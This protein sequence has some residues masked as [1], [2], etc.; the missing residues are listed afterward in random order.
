MQRLTQ[1]IE[2]IRAKLDSLRRLSLKET[3]TRSIIID[4]L[5]E[6]LGWDIRNPN[7]VEQEYPTVDGKSVDYALKINGKPML[8]V[9]AKALDDPLNDVKAITQVVG[10]AANA[11]IVWCILTNGVKWKVYRSVEKCAAPDKQ[12]FEVCLDPRESGGIAVPQLAEQLW[13][14][15]RDET[16]KG[17]LDVL[18][19][20]IST[21]R[22]VFKALD[23]IMRDPPKPI[24]NAA[25]AS[26]GDE[27]LNPLKIKESIARIWGKMGLGALPAA[28]LAP[29][30][31]P[32][33]LGSARRETSRKAAET[34]RRIDEEGCYNEDRHLDGKPQEIV[35]LFR[36]IDGFC[37]SLRPG[38]VVKRVRKVYVSYCCG[39][40][41]FCYVTIFQRSVTL[42]LRLKYGLIQNPPP[43]A[44]D[45]S[46]QRWGTCEL[47]LT[48]SSLAQLEE[49]RPLVCDS[50]ESR[51]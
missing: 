11:G 33:A 42:Y 7:E 13:L 4:P 46:S 41:T 38:A 31:G 48:I 14:F 2:S 32:D 12:M 23:T 39:G 1:A 18:G 9:E 15:S 16:A 45:V 8:L 30:N 43:F 44:R 29:G 49:A 17:T 37:L 24:V 28:V 25:R 27:S 50:L 22:K 21:D 35:E 10:Y 36:A 26:I 34:R 6:A 47:A 40:K 19:E 5:L 20:Q 51:A 3:P